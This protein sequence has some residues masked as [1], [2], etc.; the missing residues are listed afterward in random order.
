M[1]ERARAS[2]W[3]GWKEKWLLVGLGFLRGV[4]RMV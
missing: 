1:N 3:V 2:G 4:L